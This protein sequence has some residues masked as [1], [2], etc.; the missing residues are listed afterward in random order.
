MHMHA[1][2]ARR[3]GLRA[4]GGEGDCPEGPAPWLSLAFPARWNSW[5]SGSLGVLRGGEA[6]DSDPLSPCGG[7]RVALRC[8]AAASV[9]WGAWQR[10]GWSGLCALRSTCERS[11][12]TCAQT[13]GSAR[14]TGP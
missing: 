2:A 14:E 11:Q 5:S 9:I 10:D 4:G 13:V 1:G 3:V 8:W 12:T 7:Q 6:V